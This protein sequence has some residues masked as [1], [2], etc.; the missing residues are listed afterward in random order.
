MAI[1]KEHSWGNVDKAE[2]QAEK[3][4]EFAHVRCR[5]DSPKEEGGLKELSGEVVWEIPRRWHIY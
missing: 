4:R 3:E 2:H 1:M 5:K